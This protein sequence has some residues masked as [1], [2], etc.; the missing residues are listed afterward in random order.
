[1]ANNLTDLQDIVTEMKTVWTTFRCSETQVNFNGFHFGWASEVDDIHSKDLPLMIVNPPTATLDV[2]NLSREYGISENFYTIQIYNYPPSTAYGSQPEF[3]TS[4]WDNI[5]SCFYIW[6]QQ[7]LNNLGPSKVILSSGTIQ[8]TRT[9][10]AS[11]D[12]FF[13][14]QFTFTLQTYRT[15]LTLQ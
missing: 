8:I 12:S 11:N 2:A 4:L 5:E 14:S 1:M 15:C 10:E 13:M 6:L 3:I 7:V 9:K